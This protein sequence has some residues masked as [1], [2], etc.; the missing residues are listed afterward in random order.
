MC[1]YAEIN[2]SIYLAC[3]FI[4]AMRGTSVGRQSSHNFILGLV[5]SFLDFQLVYLANIHVP[6]YKFMTVSMQQ[7]LKRL[8]VVGL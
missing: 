1:T 3:L 2:L 4:S 8:S 6:V 5:L 7:L